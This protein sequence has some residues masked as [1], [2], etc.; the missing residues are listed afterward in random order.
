MD[1]IL[2]NRI[3]KITASCDVLVAGGGIAGIA[4]ALAARRAGA[5]VL[6]LEREYVLGG[7]AT[8]G[9]V[10]VYLPLDDGAGHQMSFGIAEEL[11]RLSTVHA[12]ENREGRNPAAWLDGGTFEEKRDG[13]R[14]EVQFNPALFAI[15]CEKL[16]LN[17]GVRILYGTIVCDVHKSGDLIDSVIIENKSG[18]SAVR[19]R[20]VVDCTGDADICLYAGA[21]TETF[22]QG[23]VLAAW[24]YFLGSG[25]TENQLKMLGY[26]DIPEN[27]KK[28]RWPK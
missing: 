14:F 20:S 21:P 8:A 2:E 13:H 9:L 12:R 26:A 7:L 18:R 17:E 10:T 19:I 1:Y 27:E 5:D 4:A 25:Q 15:E 11:L 28:K 3:T 6:L 16:L 23:N 22:R 24:Y